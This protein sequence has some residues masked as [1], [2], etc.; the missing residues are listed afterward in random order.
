ML[1]GFMTTD[2]K[3]RAETEHP[4]HQGKQSSAI[5][6]LP[7]H[8]TTNGSNVDEEKTYPF[9]NATPKLKLATL[10]ISHEYQVAKE[11]L[12][13]RDRNNNIILENHVSEIFV[14]L[15]DKKENIHFEQNRVAT[16]PS[17]MAPEVFVKS[18]R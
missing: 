9:K 14:T 2:L 17:E 11:T 3:Q 4:R 6:T 18:H 10:D 12:Q 16:S 5:T 7:Q 1:P 8:A 13:D 15:V